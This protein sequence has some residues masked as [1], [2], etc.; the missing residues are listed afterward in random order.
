MPR[1]IQ[2]LLSPAALTHNL[3]VVRQRLAEASTRL[4]RPAP[5]IW[6][7]IKANAYG[8][9][10]DLGV[11][12]F[13]QADGLAML[14]F[15][16]AIRCRELGWDKPILLLEGFFDAADLLLIT[17][18][19]LSIV[20]HDESQLRALQ[21][22]SPER[23]IGVYLKI[24]TGMNRLGFAGATV[25]VAWYALRH[26]QQQKVIRFLGSMTHFALADSSEDQT[27]AQIER[28]QRLNP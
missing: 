8:H 10:I 2:L 26:L 12:A 6:A 3:A 27:F 25:D 28:F 15:N 14:D 20:V 21:Q 16:E 19:N 18:H 5:H 24:N 7:V 13:A 17:R 11:K 22:F 23:P 4:Q 1:P 9:G